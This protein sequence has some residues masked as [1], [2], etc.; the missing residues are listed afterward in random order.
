MVSTLKGPIADEKE[1]KVIGIHPNYPTEPTV[2][3]HN[4]CMHLEET[5]TPTAESRTDEDLLDAFCAGE[6]TALETIYHRHWQ[7]IYDY[8]VSLLPGFQSDAEDI[9]QMIFAFLIEHPPHGIH[10][11][12]AFLYIKAYRLI[13]NFKR[14]AMRLRRDCRRTEPLTHDIEDP[15]SPTAQVASLLTQLAPPQAKAIQ[16]RLNGHTSQSAAE[17]LGVPRTTFEWWYRQ[18]LAVLKKIGLDSA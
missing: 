10:C 12:Q 18:G 8:T 5:L 14:D 9:A 13:Q 6:A 1:I 11:L 16:M 15:G 3:A 17:T 2:I 4:L 7:R